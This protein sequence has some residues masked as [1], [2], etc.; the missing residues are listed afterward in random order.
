MKV[1]S[2]SYTANYCGLAE[3][4]TKQNKRNNGL[5]RAR[6]GASRYGNYS[7]GYKSRLVKLLTLE[8]KKK[9]AISQ[10]WLLKKEKPSYQSFSL[11][12]S[13]QKM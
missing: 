12:V 6:L 2:H 13:Y 5:V 4:K 8:N 9:A 7:H 10:D 11:M 3:L 1:V